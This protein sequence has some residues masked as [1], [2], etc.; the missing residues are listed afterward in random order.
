[1]S[2]P[3]PYDNGKVKIGLLWNPPLPEVDSDMATIQKALCPPSK[4]VK[5]GAIDD[6]KNLIGD[7]LLLILIAG[8][9]LFLT[10][11]TALVNHLC[12]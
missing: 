7:A 6:L 2:K 10:Y 3:A 1:M 9:V 12:K 8:F 11:P 4:R 5:G